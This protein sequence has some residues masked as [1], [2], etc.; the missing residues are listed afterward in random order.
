MA[1]P[2]AENFEVV[3]KLGLAA[4]LIE[5]EPHTH[6]VLHLDGADHIGD[7]KAGPGR[8]VAEQPHTHLT[9]LRAQTSAASVMLTGAC[10]SGPSFSAESSPTATRFLIVRSETRR[11]SATSATVKR[12]LIA[13]KFG[14]H[15]PGTCNSFKPR[16]A[17]PELGP[18]KA[19]AS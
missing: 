19:F 9:I 10:C 18:K 17:R 6:P 13:S 4:Q 2:R 5:I 3:V 8:R 16:I 11:R 7:E 14:C 1:M 15:T 12:L